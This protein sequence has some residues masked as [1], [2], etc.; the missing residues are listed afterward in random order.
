MS[1]DTWYHLEIA[2]GLG[3]VSYGAY[4]LK[5]YS[6]KLELNNCARSARYFFLSSPAKKKK[7]AKDL[8]L[9]DC[10]WVGYRQLVPIISRYGTPFFRPQNFV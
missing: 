6:L 8:K 1:L 4:Y 2:Y 3:S 10:I 5:V 9:G 7:T